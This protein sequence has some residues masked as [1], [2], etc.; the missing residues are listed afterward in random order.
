[1]QNQLQ[2]EVFG[3]LTDIM[4][5]NK[6]VHNINN[7]GNVGN[8]INGNVNQNGNLNGT[9]RSFV[10]GTGRNYHN[11]SFTNNNYSLPADYDNNNI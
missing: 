6:S 9:Q 4:Y 7:N 3:F 8:D 11:N 5:R 10:V 1:M 2:A